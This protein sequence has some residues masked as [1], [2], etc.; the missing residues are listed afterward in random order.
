MIDIEFNIQVD[1]AQASED[2][3]LDDYELALMIDHTKAQI[4]RQVQTALGSLVCAEHH[5][6]PRV[7]ISGA[8][9]LETEQLEI[10]YHV[11]TC[12]KPFLMEAVRALNRQ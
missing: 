10:S 12:C 7:I 6:P 4:T 1:E 8:Y 5:Q 2:R 11:D 3:I 9:S